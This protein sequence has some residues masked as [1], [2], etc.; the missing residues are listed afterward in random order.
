MNPIAKGF[1]I[2]CGGLAVVV[3]VGVVGL[4]VWLM[5]GPEGGV[6]LSNE[7]DQYAL[8]YIA[9]HD[10]LDPDEEL[11]AYFDVTL[12]MDG[13][14]AAILTSDRV[15]YHNAGNTT[16]IRVE[17]I[18]DVSHRY[19]SLVGDVIEIRSTSG[20]VMKI[21]IAPF[22]LGETFNNVLMNIWQKTNDQTEP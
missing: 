17:D 20:Q 16:S 2:G 13:T 22:N 18:E 3:L 6:K 14:E 1:L 11:L 19:E 8:D 4:G 9:A 12:A 7:M 10:F 21:E 5:S 15:I